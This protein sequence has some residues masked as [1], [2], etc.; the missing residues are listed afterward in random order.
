MNEPVNDLV[1][2]GRF[3]GPAASGNGGATAPSTG[4]APA[5]MPSP[6]Q[7]AMSTTPHRVTAMPTSVDVRNATPMSSRAKTA[8]QSGSVLVTG[9]TTCTRP[10]RSA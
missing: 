1:V 6:I 10:A 4:P 5:A 3:C 8:V 7:R 9:A 2:P